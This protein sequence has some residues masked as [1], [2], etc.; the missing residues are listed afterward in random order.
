MTSTKSKSHMLL[1]FFFLLSSKQL[2]SKTVSLNRFN[3][4][5]EVYNVNLVLKVSF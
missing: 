1:T 5:Q 3:I 2:I 4:I